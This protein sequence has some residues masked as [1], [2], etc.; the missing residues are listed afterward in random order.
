[1]TYKLYYDTLPGNKLMINRLSRHIKDF[2]TGLWRGTS[3]IQDMMTVLG[4]DYKWTNNAKDP[5]AIVVIE[6]ESQPPEILHKII[7]M[8]SNTYK[9]CIVACTTEQPCIETIEALPSIQKLHPNVLITFGGNPE[10]NFKSSNMVFYPYYL[11]KP[12]IFDISVKL[13]NELNC[14]GL[15]SSKP[16]IFNHLSRMWAREKYHTHYTIMNHFE[17]KYNKDR[18][19]GAMLSYRPI[20][21][22]GDAGDRHQKALEGLKYLA[23]E[24]DKRGDDPLTR[25]LYKELYPTKDYINRADPNYPD[26]YGLL[27]LY[28]DPMYDDEGNML[29]VGMR[30]LAHPIGVYSRSHIALVTE[31]ECAEWDSTYLAKGL[32]FSHENPN[33]LTIKEKSKSTPST[34]FNSFISEKTVQPILNKQIFIVGNTDLING[35]YNTDFLKRCLGFELFEEVFDYQDIENENKFLTT[36]KVI[37]QLNNFKEEVIFDNARVLGEKLH[38]NR[39]L[40]ANPN[41]ELR[42]KL[43]K[44]FVE[45]LLDKFLEMDS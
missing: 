39:D 7:N 35:S 24:N 12:F 33:P 36:A 2:T 45:D 20:N 4:I 8:A 32:G 42:K 9:K 41:S 18:G 5:E 43:K 40:M 34:V 3:V 17:R 22:L 38:Y 1:M 16:Y 19:Y 23:I 11:L 26:H 6:V 10:L 30:D 27:K 21:F 31:I 14:N 25:G 28:D 15:T 29:D 44:W 13:H 37:E